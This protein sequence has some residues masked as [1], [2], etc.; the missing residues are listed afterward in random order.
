MYNLITIGDALIDTHVQI[1]DATVNCDVNREHCHLCLDYASKVPIT[2]S[3]Q[4]LG[5][6]AANVACGTV[7]LGLKTAILS[8]I[9]A[10]S[11][12][13]LIK[14]EL[15]KYGVDTTLVSLDKKTKTRYSVVLN[16]QGER[17]IL[18]FHRRREYQWP[19]KFPATGWIYY[20]GMSEGYE[21]FQ[22]DL[23]DWIENHAG[24]RVVFNPGSY[25]IKET[26][27]SVRDMLPFTDIL[28][29]NVEEAERILDTT[30]RKEK[31]A[32]ALARELLALGVKEVAITDA[33]RGAI[34]CTKENIWQMASYPVKV[35]AKTG[36]GDAFSSGYTVARHT[37]LDITTALQWGIANSCAVIGQMGAQTGLL[38][39]AGI[40]KMIAQY[41]E[42]KPSIV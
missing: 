8:S 30:I 11:N 39:Q 2:D 24:A 27:D 19:K 9:G 40:K 5:G 15:K 23:I 7:R 12:G 16:F 37:G 29:V 18:S 25:Q 41:S 21:N 34:A 31:T 35:V 28:I 13:K 3:F 4:C 6:N 10:D 42:T 32:I 17:T 33:G 36:A 38:D 26:L 22:N 20:T 14:Q 1:D